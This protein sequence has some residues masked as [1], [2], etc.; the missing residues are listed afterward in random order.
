MKQ[1][2]TDEEDAGPVLQETSPAASKTERPYGKW[3]A[4]TKEEDP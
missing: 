3:E 4:I 1:E 2:S